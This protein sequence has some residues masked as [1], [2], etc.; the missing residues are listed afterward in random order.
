MAAWGVRRRTV[1]DVGASNDAAAAAVNQRRH[2]S[3]LRVTT[4]AG[5]LV[6]GLAGGAF[7]QESGDVGLSMGYPASI[8]VTWHVTDRV[9]IRPEVSLHWTSSEAQLAS[10]EGESISNESFSTGLG[11]SVLFYLGTT[12]RLRTYITPRLAY[13]RTSTSIETSFV[14]DRDTTLDGFQVSGSFGA[15]YAVGDRFSVF[16]EV[17]VAYSSLS[18]DLGLPGID[19]E[20][21]NRSFGTRTTAGVTLYF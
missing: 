15:Q 19:S 16:G 4:L 13:Q 1:S 11:A 6:L 3:T 18:G 8:A 21:R 2:M 7:A 5:L 9:A 20:S 12:D 14:P 10:I 17:G